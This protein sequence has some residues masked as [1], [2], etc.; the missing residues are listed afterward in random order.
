MLSS[1]SCTVAGVNV[2]ML[3]E[4]EFVGLK[5][6]RIRSGLIKGSMVLCVYGTPLFLGYSSY[7]K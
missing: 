7:T 4:G 3:S 6:V 1:S 5:R 2:H